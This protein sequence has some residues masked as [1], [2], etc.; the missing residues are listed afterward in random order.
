[1]SGSYRSPLSLVNLAEVLTAILR[2]GLQT[3]VQVPRSRDLG[4]N[5]GIRRRTQ[6]PSGLGPSTPYMGIYHL[7]F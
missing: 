5:S 3:E 2:Y 6:R 4:S 1:M 7:S